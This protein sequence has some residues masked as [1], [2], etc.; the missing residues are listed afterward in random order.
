MIS[1]PVGHPARRAGCQWVARGGTHAGEC[2]RPAHHLPPRQGAPGWNLDAHAT[3]FGGI[4]E[5][6]GGDAAQ[7]DGSGGDPHRPQARAYRGRG[8]TSAR[9]AHGYASL[10]GLS[11]R[12]D[13]CVLATSRYSSRRWASRSVAQQSRCDARMTVTCAAGSTGLTRCRSITA[14]V[15]LREGGHRGCWGDPIGCHGNTGPGFPP[16][17][18]ET[19]HRCLA[20]ASTPSRPN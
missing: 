2:G 6:L 19:L 7:A 12:L 8:R 15:G 13:P 20:Q 4:G 1:W 14:S 3:R 18:L 5:R 17:L 11:P 10:R 16:A 9:L